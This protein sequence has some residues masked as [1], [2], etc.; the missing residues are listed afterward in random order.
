MSLD[1]SKA[2]DPDALPGWLDRLRALAA[3]AAPAAAVQRRCEHLQPDEASCLGG[4]HEL[5]GSRA[6]RICP[7][8]RIRAAAAAHAA[9]LDRCGADAAAAARGEDPVPALVRALKPVAGTRD[10]PA[11]RDMLREATAPGAARHRFHLGLHGSCGTGK[12]H[13]LLTLYFLAIRQGLR[14]VWTSWMQWREQAQQAESFDEEQALKAAAWF[15]TAERA[16]VVII[17]DVLFVP[18][19]APAERTRVLSR[20]GGYLE[21]RRGRTL[22]SANLGLKQLR[23]EEALGERIV[24]RLLETRVLPDGTRVPLCVLDLTGTDQRSRP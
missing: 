5:S 2:M 6:V 20:L 21:R 18:W 14:A 10:L 1:V 17:D 19:A 12:S 13:A 8:P 22:L 11:L 7:A 15:D 3:D 24:S 4:A 16:D 9:Q 23:A